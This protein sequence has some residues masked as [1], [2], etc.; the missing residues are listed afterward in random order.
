M[1]YF[2]SVLQ[3]EI[4]KDIFSK[5]FELYVCP[6]IDVDY[7]STFG[8]FEIEANLQLEGPNFKLKFWDKNSQNR[9]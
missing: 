8:I 2:N 1:H 7:K 6:D 9:L 5:D 4:K 3:R